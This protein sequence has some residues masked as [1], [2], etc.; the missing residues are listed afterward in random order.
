MLGTSTNPAVVRELNQALALVRSKFKIEINSCR[1]HVSNWFGK[2][3]AAE[4]M[5]DIR[6]HGLDVFC[7]QADFV[8]TWN[9]R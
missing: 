7:E 9:E 3:G 4:L 6:G 2:Q 8:I 5:E 1:H